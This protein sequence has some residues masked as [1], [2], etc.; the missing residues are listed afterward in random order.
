MGMSVLVQEVCKSVMAHAPASVS[1]PFHQP[2]LVNEVLTYLAP[3][4]GS[5][6]VDATCGTGGHSAAILPRLV[7]GGR[8][9]AID[10]DGSALA[11][12]RQRLTEWQGMVTF[13][14]ANFRELPALLRELHVPRIDGLLVD[15]GMSSLQVDRAERGFSFLREGPLDMRMDAGQPVTAASLVNDLPEAG[16]AHLVETLGE[17]RFAR[18][19][20]RAI[21]AARR[22][23]PFTTTTQL[24][25]VIARA[26]PRRDGQGRLHPATRTFQALRIAVNDELGALE[27]TLAAL[28][29]LLAP[30]QG[31]AVI[32]SFHS[33]EDRRVKQAFRAGEQD[34]IWTRLTKK[35]VRPGP[36]ETA[37]NPRARS[38][39]LRAVE[40]R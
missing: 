34:H 13:R 33:L 18:R 2:V 14:R 12:A 4:P 32:L 40:K 7:P 35:V 15:L 9:I 8:L 39:R 3:R 10:R 27:A 31:R 38:V 30:G 19:I 26:V 37:R 36:E 20:A 25:G 29:G 16:L 21:V 22:T 17:D 6:I 5:V 28:P 24:A 1:E 11:I 23:H